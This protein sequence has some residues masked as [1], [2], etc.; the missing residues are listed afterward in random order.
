[1]HKNI[2][3]HK[4]YALAQKIKNK[5]IYVIFPLVGSPEPVYIFIDNTKATKH[6]IQIDYG[7]LVEMVLNGR[8]MGSLLDHVHLPM[9]H[10]GKS[11]KI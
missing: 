3:I 5:S 1:M 7:K 4:R 11:L 2:S 6:E 9:I 8:S 10:Y